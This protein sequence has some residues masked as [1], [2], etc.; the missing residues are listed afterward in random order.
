MTAF[1]FGNNEY[2]NEI[3]ENISDIYDKIYVLTQNKDDVDKKNNILYFDLSDE[4]D[5][6]LELMIEETGVAFCVLDNDANNIFLTI[7]LRARF[8]NLYIVSLS[9]DDE[10]S[11]KLKRAGATK[12]LPIVDITASVIFD[13]IEKPISST[14]LHTIM[15]EKTNLKISQIYIGDKSNIVGK[16]LHDIDFTK[17]IVVAVIDHNVNTEFIFTTQGHNHKLNIDDVLVIIGYDDD[18]INFKESIGA[19]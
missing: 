11:T 13:I 6:L 14:M 1:I 10:S 3:Y 8:E 2:T 9:T 5:D 7:S 15:Y 18:I 17:I 12:V 4:W 19:I 16:Y